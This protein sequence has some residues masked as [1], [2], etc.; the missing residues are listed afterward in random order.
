[1]TVDPQ[2][3]LGHGLVSG[4]TIPDPADVRAGV[5]YGYDNELIGTMAG[6][7]ASTTDDY[8]YP[9]TCTISRR[10]QTT[11]GGVPVY[12]AL[13]EPV[14]GWTPDV[15]ETAC[16]FQD[17]GTRELARRFSTIIEANRIYFPYGTTI[18]TGD[19]IINVKL[20][21][22]VLWAGPYEVTGIMQPGN[23]TDHFEIE[24]GAVTG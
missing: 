4:I 18:A 22:T 17:R 24:L 8:L 11:A 1:M 5:Q 21:T 13:H 14:Y 15:A 20:G 7:V 19:K 9:H 3:V 6:A 23:G 2:S 10:A 16:F 12:N